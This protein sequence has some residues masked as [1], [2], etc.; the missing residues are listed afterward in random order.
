MAASP[1]ELFAPY[2]V[3]I[4]LALLG[5]PRAGPGPRCTCPKS[6]AKMRA[7]K[8]SS[9][10]IASF[11]NSFFALVRLVFGARELVGARVVQQDRI[12]AGA[13]YVYRSLAPRA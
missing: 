2:E 10:A 4:L 6:Q 13:I 9:A 8:L 3:R 11:K 5:L 7:E 1:E 12:G